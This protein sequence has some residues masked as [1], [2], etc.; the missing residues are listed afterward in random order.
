MANNKSK[1][2]STLG[3]RLTA[4]VSVTLVLLI[5]G[6]MMTGAAA[7]SAAAHRLRGSVTLVAKLNLGSTDADVAEMK[8]FFAKAPWTV[9]SMYTSADEVLSQELE[10]NVDIKDLID[11]NPFSGEFEVRIDENYIY[12]DSLAK[13]SRQLESLEQVDHVVLPMEIADGISRMVSNVQIVLGI[14]AAA[15]LLISIVLIYNTVSLSVYSRRLVIHS[16]KLVG[17]TPGFI[18][19]PFIKSGL[20]SGALAGVI[21]SAVMWL[22]LAWAD[23]QAAA[24]GLQMADLATGWQYMAGICA[25]LIVSGTLIC[26][27]S[28]LFAANRYIGAAYDDYFK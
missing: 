8:R 18:R 28:S 22:L 21:A 27:I 7:A 23:S 3:S 25:V 16:M 13:I 19:A 17:A 12:A 15:L 24:L 5:I 4:V 2:I 6:I 14:I 10:Y 11:E 1:K 9:E 26:G 20:A